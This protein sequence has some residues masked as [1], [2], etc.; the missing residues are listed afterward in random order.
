M[1]SSD[2]EQLY[3]CGMVDVEA[4]GDGPGTFAGLEAP[5]PFR[6][7]PVGELRVPAEH[8]VTSLGSGTAGIGPANYALT[9]ILGER[10]QEGNEAPACRS[11]QIQ[12][13]LVEDFDQRA[14]PVMRSMMWT[15]PSSSGL[16]GPIRPRP[17]H[18]RCRV[19]REILPA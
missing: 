17:G 15:P 4:P 3:D 5:S 14:A 2:S 10:A 19:R 8:H 11:R 16:R 7:L 12:V 9:L 6:L 1:P 13:G 18:P